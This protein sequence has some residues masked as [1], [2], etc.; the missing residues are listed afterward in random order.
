MKLESQSPPPEERALSL[1]DFAAETLDF[2]SVRAI[3]ERF[4]LSSLGLSALRELAPLS[5]SEA[6]AA[7]GRA[8]EMQLLDAAGDLPGLAGVSDLAPMLEAARDHGRALEDDAIVALRAFVGAAE[9]LSDW[10][11]RRRTDVPAIGA[12]GQGLPDLEALREQ[13]DAR[14]DTRGRVRDD[15]TPQLSAAKREEGEL[16]RS[17]DRTLEGLMRRPEIKNALIDSNRHL[18][19]GRL[20]LAVKAKSAGR[21]RGLHHDR[22][23]SE[24]TVFVEPREVVEPGNRLADCRARV[25]NEIAR[26]LLELTRFVLQC[27]QELRLAAERIAKL[28]LALIGVHFAKAFEAR[29]PKLPGEP[30]AAA[31]LLLRS[32]RHPLLVDQEQRG[33]LEEVVPIDLRLGEHFDMLIV[34]GPNTGGKTLA[35]KTAGLFALCARMGLPVPCA[36]GSTVPLYSGVVAD[37]GDEQEISQ[38]L[39]TFS[40][41]LVRIREGLLRAER[42]TLVLVDELGGGTDPDE[43]AA[44]GEA[45]LDELLRRGVPTIASTHLGK[46]KEFAFRH[47]RAEN[48]CV[49]FDAETLEPRYRILLGTPG[50]SGAL[51]VAERLG[52][53]ASVVRRAEERLE[54]RDGELLQL[55][56]DVRHARTEAERVRSQAEERLERAEREGRAVEVKR[57]ELERRGDLLE[58]EAQRGIEERVRDARRGLERLRA[59]VEQL[60]GTHAE[61][62][63]ASIAV[64]EETLSN[65]SLSERRELFLRGLNKGGLVYLPR[66][67]KRCLVHKVDRGRREVT[68]KLGSMKIKV[69]FDEITWYE[70]L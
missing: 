56:S 59:L 54:R 67:R 33:E 55:M 62:I 23:Q 52:L 69:A 53:P 31:G 7:V 40:S 2:A 25:R 22:S 35:L 60:P 38:S 47:A 11:L 4:A 48:A 28:E 16:Q 39:S 49:E 27:E 29:I 24:Q 41:H 64:V 45:I 70:S 19:G 26:I 18:R 34:T 36:E 42:D 13:I 46:L 61:K 63:R 44:L 9:R 10:M 66:Y 17:I 50:E 5:E 6:R 20:V 30:G 21:V 1:A 14:V 12:L 58:A 32:A 37:I 51:V 3:Y 43:G 57:Q 15:A 65:A 8:R 68:V